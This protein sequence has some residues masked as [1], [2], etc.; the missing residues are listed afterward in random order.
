MEGSSGSDVPSSADWGT[1][2]AAI[3]MI[4]EFDDADFRGEV[5][6]LARLLER[7]GLSAHRSADRLERRSVFTT[8]VTP[9]EHGR[10]AILEKTSRWHDA[11]H[12]R[13]ADAYL[14]N[15]SDD[16]LEDPDQLRQQA[17]TLLDAAQIIDEMLRWY[18]LR[19][20]ALYPSGRGHL[21][22]DTIVAIM[23]D[24]NIGP[25]ETTRQ[26]AAHGLHVTVGKLKTAQMRRRRDTQAGNVTPGPLR[27][28]L[29]QR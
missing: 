19:V 4:G 25:A 12:R 23:L 14:A 10:H 11:R 29:R 27:V 18:E 5:E 1:A 8:E 6:Q 21:M 9:S 28:L 26:L 15:L 3:V 7:E 17:A 2:V 24:W 22:N 16:G 13:V 20:A